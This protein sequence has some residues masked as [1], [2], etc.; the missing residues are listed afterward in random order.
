MSNQKE[1]RERVRRAYSPDGT[2]GQKHIAFRCDLENL[3]WLYQQPNKGRYINNLIEA[4][5]QQRQKP[6]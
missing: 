4:D 1:E 6:N 5:R 3:E 2:R